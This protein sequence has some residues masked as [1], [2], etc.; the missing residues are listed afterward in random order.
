MHGHGSIGVLSPVISGWYF[1]T[2]LSGAAARAGRSR[3]RVMA[4]Q[5]LPSSRDRGEDMVAP[6]L[7]LPLATEQMAGIV[8]VTTAVRDEDLPRLDDLGKPIVFISHD[9]DPLDAPVVVPDNAG[10]VRRAVEHLLGHGHQA[11]GFVGNM[12]QRDMRERHD[13]YRATLA[14]HGIVAQERWLFETSDNLEPGGAGAARAMLSAGMPTTA[15]VVATDRN[16]IGLTE[17]L[18]A[19]GVRLP[20]EQAIVGFDGVPF[21]AFVEPRLTTVVPHTRRLGHM[22]AHLLLGRIAGEQVRPGR[23]SPPASLLVRESCGCPAIPRPARS[24]AADAEAGPVTTPVVVAGV[25][26]TGGAASVAGVAPTAV[27]NEGTGSRPTSRTRR[28]AP[29]DWV[30]AALREAAAGHAVDVVALGRRLDEWLRVEPST[31]PVERLLVTVRAVEAE[32]L[33]GGTLGPAGSESLRRA[34]TETLLAVTRAQ[35]R[36]HAHRTRHLESLLAHQY[37]M[38]MDLLQ[39]GEADPRALA[40]LPRALVAGACLGLWTGPE[41]ED[42]RPLHI[43]GTY[44]ADNRLDKLVGT[45]A[46]A[47]T[48]PPT[49]LT[50]LTAPDSGHVVFVVPL[51]S[52]TRDWGVLAVVAPPE[53]RS[54]VGRGMENHWAALAAIALDQEELFASLRRQQEELTESYARERELAD[55]VR[56]SEE[57]YALAVQAA[58]D[59]LWD[60]DVTSGRVYYSPRCK[61]ILGLAE[62]DVSDAPGEWLDRVHPDDRGEVTAAV[63]AQLNGAST[64]LESEHRLRAADGSYRWVSCRALAVLDEAGTPA[65]LVGAFTDV[66]QRRALEDQLRAGAL[67]DAATGLPSVELLRD[68]LTR[69]VRRSDVDASYHFTVVAAVVDLDIVREHGGDVATDVVLA[70]VGDRLRAAV[71]PLDT[72]AR[73]A[74]GDFAVVLDGVAPDSAGEVVERLRDRLAGPYAVHGSEVTVPVSVRV[75]AGDQPHPSDDDVWRRL[76]IG[77]QRARLRAR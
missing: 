51:R 18:A 73:V 75:V 28:D 63:A 40:W 45:D 72:A 41:R 56:A 20:A 66:T 32:L 50:T 35:L 33:A 53:F 64:P 13:A 60:W 15:V 1:G 43:V 65:R 31:E 69:V 71:G 68:R 7:G 52:D 17:E 16:A 74:G 23:Y 5:T 4:V 46:T 26:P 77:I 29:P 21:G 37:D 12:W 11:I 70:A 47:A 59:G 19:A 9:A 54:L 42:D 44:D 67:R 27:E 38:D 3:R 6:P 49:A 57:R 14:E 36:A 10:G 76:E 48:F 61:A 62:D 2:L 34:A 24:S 22:A 58:N 55:G 39:R 8:V 25:A 30:A